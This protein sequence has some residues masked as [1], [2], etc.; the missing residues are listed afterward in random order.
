MATTRR[1]D[2]IWGGSLLAVS[3]VLPFVGINGAPSLPTALSLAAMIAFAAAMIVFAFGR[4]SVVARRGLGAAA[5]VVL[6]LSVF[7]PYL[8]G[9]VVPPDQISP[10]SGAILWGTLLHYLTLALSL[11]AALVA[12]VQIAR[13]GVVPP[14]LRWVPIMA[15]AVKAGPFALSEI[16][17]VGVGRFAGMDA[18]IALAIL[19]SLTSFVAVAGLGVVA[20][21]AGLPPRAATETAVPV[22]S[23]DTGSW[24]EH[25][26]VEEQRSAG[27]PPRP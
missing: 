8:S 24:R 27:Q 15:L 14:R 16:L 12:C 11:A 2:W 17:M 6:A 26:T 3:A 21:V 19:P 1:L 7:L 22:F 18:L 4:H 9:L 20:I 5:L 10:D 23:S 13:A 25:G